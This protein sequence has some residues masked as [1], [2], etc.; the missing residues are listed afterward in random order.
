[1]KRRI[2]YPGTPPVILGC[3][4][5]GGRREKEG[6]F[7]ALFDLTDKTDRFRKKT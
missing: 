2:L 6:P 7:G 5:V 3:A 1:M 4:T